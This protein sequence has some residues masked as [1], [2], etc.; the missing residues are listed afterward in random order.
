M[1]SRAEKSLSRVRSEFYLNEQVYY[2]NCGFSS[3]SDP[4][5]WTHQNEMIKAKCCVENEWIML[6]GRMP[7]R[8]RPVDTGSRLD[9]L[10]L[11]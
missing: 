3:R 8:K 6:C 2:I 5:I 7:A 10:R 4:N 11:D 1:R 9:Q